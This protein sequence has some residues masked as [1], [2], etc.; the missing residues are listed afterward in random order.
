MR[1]AAAAA[2]RAGRRARPTPPRSPRTTS[3]SARSCGRTSATPRSFVHDAIVRGDNVMFEGAQGVLLDVDHG[4]YPFVTSSSTTAGGACAGLGIG[5]TAIDTVMGIA[6]GYATRVG[7]GPFPTELSDAT[8]DLLR[9]RGNEFGSV[10]GPA[11]PLRLARHAGA[12][13]RHPP[14]GD[15]GAR[16]DEARRAGGARARPRSASATA[17]A[18]DPGRDAARHRRARR[19]RADLR[20]ARRLAGGRVVGHAAL[21]H[22]GGGAVRRAGG[23]VGRAARSGRRRGVRGGPRPS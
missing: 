11:A 12:A 13:A 6:K 15:R 18:A 1:G 7:G 4:T 23:G 22:Q 17:W 10:T 2:A 14:V 5:P 9:K 19:G 21:G 16:A 8:G 3:R 20:G